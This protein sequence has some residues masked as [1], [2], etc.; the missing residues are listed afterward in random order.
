MIKFRSYL[1]VGVLV[2]CVTLL[3]SLPASIVTGQLEKNLGERFQE[4]VTWGTLWTG[5]SVFV[6]DSY[7]TELTWDLDVK[8]L[9]LFQLAGNVQLKM[10]PMT[11]SFFLQYG[12]GGLVIRNLKGVFYAQAV[13]DV[14]ARNG[15]Q[16]SFEEDIYIRDVSLTRSKNEFASAQGKLEWTGG[17]VRAKNLPDQQV[18]LPALGAD[19]SRIESGLSIRFHERANSTLLAELDLSHDGRAHLK[20]RERVADYVS[21]P[22]QLKMGNP[23]SVMFEIKQQVF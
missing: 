12:F 1:L 10:Q 15:V 17:M 11:A 13:S 2:Y 22:A 20:L 4:S 23:D 18:T 8:R 21:V 9:L 16:A 6:L 5:R 19:I 7:K 14:L 3:A